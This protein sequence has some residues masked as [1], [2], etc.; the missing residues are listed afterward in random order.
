[1]T[2][3]VRSPAIF[4]QLMDPE[5]SALLRDAITAAGVKIVAGASVKSVRSGNG[6]VTG[7]LLDNAR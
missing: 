2:L 5:D 4:S 1:M 7:V 3:V 6:G